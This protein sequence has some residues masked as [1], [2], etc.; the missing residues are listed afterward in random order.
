MS[1]L[2][3][4][5]VLREFFFKCFS[6]PW[7][8][9][10]LSFATLPIHLYGP[11]EPD[12][13]LRVSPLRLSSH[14][15]SLTVKIIE[16]HLFNLFFSFEPSLWILLLVAPGVSGRPLHSASFLLRFALTLWNH[17]VLHSFH[18]YPRSERCAIHPADVLIPWIVQE[19]TGV[20]QKVFTVLD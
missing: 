18:Y 16:N 4:Q 5:N 19:Q 2:A 10:I 6:V 13:I 3:A 12:L 1:H 17:S 15:R 7:W 14:Y 9:T 8:R 20:V 11:K